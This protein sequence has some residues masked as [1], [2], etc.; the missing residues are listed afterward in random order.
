M[1]GYC[2][3][4]WTIWGN[5]GLAVYT[6]ATANHWIYIQISQSQKGCQQIVGH[7]SYPTDYPVATKLGLCNSISRYI[8]NYFVLAVVSG[9]C[10]CLCE[11]L[12]TNKTDHW[13]HP[14]SAIMSMPYRVTRLLTLHSIFTHVCESVGGWG[15][16]GWVWGVHQR[17]H[18]IP[19]LCTRGILS[20]RGLQESW[21]F[22][23]YEHKIKRHRRYMW[24]T[25]MVEGTEYYT[26]MK[27]E[28]I[29]NKATQC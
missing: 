23:W 16:V 18:W 2:K 5:S 17:Y 3:W 8:M 21:H 14:P 27:L 20:R 6:E 9:I 10:S 28:K 4:F 15:G 13:S 7:V 11:A 22:L 1:Q 29:R 24:N 12:K 19:L 25:N 26:Q